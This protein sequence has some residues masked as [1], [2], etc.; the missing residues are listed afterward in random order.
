VKTI[1]SLTI[2]CLLLIAFVSI[3][4]G[5]YSSTANPPTYNIPPAVQYTVPTILPSAAPSNTPSIDNG[6]DLEDVENIEDAEEMLDDLEE[7]Q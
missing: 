7:A 3:A 6:T 4:F 5:S 2:T 1:I